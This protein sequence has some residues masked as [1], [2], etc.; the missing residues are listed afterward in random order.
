MQSVNSNKDPN[1]YQIN[2]NS[3]AIPVIVGGVQFYPTVHIGLHFEMTFP[4][5]YTGSL[6]LTVRF[7]NTKTDIK[8]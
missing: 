8:N 3:S 2:D 7:K 5:A 1:F 6:V 4:G